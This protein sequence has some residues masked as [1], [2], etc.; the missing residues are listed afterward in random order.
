MNKFWKRK[1]MLNPKQF[2]SKHN[3]IKLFLLC[4]NKVWKWFGVSWVQS[5]M[6]VCINVSCTNVICKHETSWWRHQNLFVDK[7]KKKKTYFFPMACNF[8]MACYDENA[9]NDSMIFF[10]KTKFFLYDVFFHIILTW[11]LIYP[12]HNFKSRNYLCNMSLSKKTKR[13]FI[14]NIL[15]N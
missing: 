13:H 15:I 9:I 5:L 11:D 3:K 7:I 2:Y 10:K 4:F 6:D 14:K 8:V 12:W 1:C